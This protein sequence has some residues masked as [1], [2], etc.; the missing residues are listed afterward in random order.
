MR[1]I[2]EPRS[3][4]AITYAVWKA[5]FLREAVTRIA[6]TRSA[7]IWLLVEPL[8]HVGFM[9]FL[10]LSVRL[11]DIGGIETA[12][13]LL[14][15][16]LP[17]FMFRRTATQA[18]NAISSNLALFTYRQVL[19]IDTVLIRAG[20]EG[21]LMVVISLI[22]FIGLALFGLDI[23]PDDPLAVLEAFGGMWL[24]GL[25]FGLVASVIN[26]LLPDV[27]KLIDLCM[28]P[29]YLISGVILPIT[30]VPQPYRDFLLL[31]P[32]AHGVEAARSGFSSYYYAVPELDMTYLW[33]CALVTVFFGLVLQRR[34]AR[35]LVML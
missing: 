23:R 28:M 12:V 13:W 3:N 11:T 20:L 27:G 32:L 18:K 19:P 1:S 7:W 16:L 6:A 24:I 15:G 17:F 4:V 8:A 30:A 2:Y 26:E 14:A 10:F 9:L 31:N 5:L 34:Y 29:L 25:G 35:R 22:L 21:L 33:A